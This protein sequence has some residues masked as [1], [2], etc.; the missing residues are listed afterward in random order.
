[1]STPEKIQLNDE[2]RAL[3][4]RTED[5]AVFVGLVYFRGPRGRRYRPIRTEARVTA[6]RAAADVTGI[7]TRPYANGA[8]GYAAD[9]LLCDPLGNVLAAER[10]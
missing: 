7:R 6:E 8:F 1:M 10:V 5:K 4:R 3:A 2:E 9:M